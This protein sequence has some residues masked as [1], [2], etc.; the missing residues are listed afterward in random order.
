MLPGTRRTARAGALLLAAVFFL[1]ACGGRA[2]RFADNTPGELSN[3]VHAREGGGESAPPPPPPPLPGALAVMIDNHP[4]ARPQS[5]LDKADV[6]YEALAEGGITRFLAIFHSR[7]AARIG[8]VRSARP[9]FVAIA[10]GYDAPF[11][12]V[13]GSDDAYAL[14]G[15]LRL[16]D[17]DEIRRAGEAYWR[18]QDRRAPHNVYTSTDRLLAAADKRGQDLRP[19]EPLPV[20]RSGGGEP[21]G[22]VRI[23]YSDNR[24]YRYVTGYRWAGGRYEKQVNGEP[25]RADGGGVVAADNVIVLLTRQR[26]T[27]DA[28][29]HMEIAVTGR[30]DALFLT[31]GRLYRGSWRKDGPDRPFAFTYENGPMRFAPGVTWINITAAV[32]V[33]VEP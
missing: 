10:R 6:V 22:G 27:G 29:G 30:G 3:L 8:P 26:P 7:P 13:G 25:L 11:A 1:A 2:G 28:A 4:N 33:A 16:P 32:G 19:L 12:H 17:L 20:G 18:S 5:G 14:I 31:G 9:Y 21:A 24:F 23:T 15:R